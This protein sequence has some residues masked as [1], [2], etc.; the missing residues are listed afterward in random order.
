MV[1]VLGDAHPP[2]G[3]SY[4]WWA[5]I[6]IDAC[7]ASDLDQVTIRS[8]ILL[9]GRIQFVHVR[10]HDALGLDGRAG[11]VRTGDHNVRQ[12]ASVDGFGIR[13]PGKVDNALGS[14]RLIFQVD[15]G[16]PREPIAKVGVLVLP[17]VAV[18]VTDG[19]N[20]TYIGRVRRCCRS[21]A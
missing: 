16:E 18:H 12:L 19:G 8:E 2:D 13:I 5:R 10:V 3:V 7:G 17:G 21:V 20:T 11:G 14:P 15:L 1:A 6:C 4:R 9:K